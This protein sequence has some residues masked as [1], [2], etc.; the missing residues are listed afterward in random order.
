MSVEQKLYVDGIE[1]DSNIVNPGEIVTMPLRI[2]SG[3]ESAEPGVEYY[4]DVTTICKDTD[5]FGIVTFPNPV[6]KQ[7]QSHILIDNFGLNLGIRLEDGR[8]GH[9]S[10]RHTP[11]HGVV[12]YKK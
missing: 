3:I 5:E 8:E 10:W 6:K 11:E 7:D 9:M 1:H 12:Y 2:T 4:L